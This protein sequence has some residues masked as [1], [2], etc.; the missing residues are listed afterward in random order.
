MR[1]TQPIVDRES[2]PDEVPATATE[3]RVDGYLTLWN[4]SGRIQTDS[5]R[6][7]QPSHDVAERTLPAC[8]FDAGRT[9]GPRRLDA[10]RGAR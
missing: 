5:C 2:S 7:S 8:R 9:P 6:L 10:T 1:T 3:I 4:G